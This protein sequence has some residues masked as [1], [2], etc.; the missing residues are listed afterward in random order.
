MGL[1]LRVVRKA[2]FEPQDAPKLT[3]E[4]LQGQILIADNLI[5]AN[6]GLQSAVDVALANIGGQ[7]GGEAG[8]ILLQALSTKA[9]NDALGKVETPLLQQ[10]VNY[11]NVDQSIADIAFKPSFTMSNPDAIAMAKKQAGDLAVQLTKE[12]HD[13]IRNLTALA[14]D[15]NYTVDQLG[16]KLRNHIGL[17]DKW[18]KAVENRYETTYKDFIKQGF[19]KTTAQALAQKAS[20]DYHARL[21]RKR[22]LMIAR[23]EVLRAEND[24]RWLGWKSAID[25]GYADPNS[26][27]RWIVRPVGACEICQS[28]NGTEIPYDQ[29]FGFGQLMPPRHPNCRCTAVLVPPPADYVPPTPPKNL[30]NPSGYTD[31]GIFTG[32]EGGKLPASAPEF[33]KPVAW[34]GQLDVGDLVYFD[35]MQ[36]TNGYEISSVKGTKVYYKTKTGTTAINVGDLLARG[37]AVAIIPGPVKLAKVTIKADIGAYA[38][39]GVPKEAVAVN[40]ITSVHVGDTLYTSTLKPGQSMSVLVVDVPNNRLKVVGATGSTYWTPFN[41]TKNQYAVVASS[42]KVKAALGLPQDNVTAPKA[43]TKTAA[44]DPVVVQVYEPKQGDVV[45]IKGD[46]STY[47]IKGFTSSNKVVLLDNNKFVMKTDILG[48]PSGAKVTASDGKVMIVKEVKG[49]KVTFQDGS[50]DL[51]SN[52]KPAHNFDVVGTTKTTFDPPPPPVQMTTASYMIDAN[53]VL[54]KQ[55]QGPTGSNVKPP[56]GFWTGTDGK[57]RYVK[58][59]ENPEQVF[60]E[61]VAN[62]MY[63]ELGI[64]VPETS[65]SVRIN[66]KTGEQEFLIVTEIVEITDSL[67][68]YNI[69]KDYAEQILDG[70][71]VDLWLANYDAVGTGWDNVVISNGKIVRIDQGGSMFFRAQGKPKDA[72]VLADTDPMQY[73]EKNAYYRDVFDAAG[74]KPNEIDS[75]AFFK[76]LDDVIAKHGGMDN[77]ILDIWGTM[78]EDSV[79]LKVGLPKPVENVSLPSYAKLL[80]MRLEGLKKAYGYK[81]QPE[82]VAPSKPVIDTG[83]TPPKTKFETGDSIQFND[84]E[85]GM[86]FANKDKT[87]IFKVTGFTKDSADGSKLIEYEILEGIKRG[88]KGLEISDDKWGTLVLADKQ[89]TYMKRGYS[90]KPKNSDSPDMTSIGEPVHSPASGNDGFVVDVTE[91]GTYIKWNGI[92]DDAFFPTDMAAKYAANGTFTKPPQNMPEFDQL[93][94]GMTFKVTSSSGTPVVVKVMDVQPDGVILKSSFVEIKNGVAT[95]VDKTDGHSIATYNALK[96]AVKVNDVSSPQP[97]PSIPVY[98]KDLDPTPGMSFI[99]E[100]GSLEAKIITSNDKGVIYVDKNSGEYV[101]V[102]KQDWETQFGKY[103]ITTPVPETITLP[104]KYLWQPKTNGVTGVVDMPGVSFKIKWMSGNFVNLEDAAGNVYKKVPKKALTGPTPGMPFKKKMSGGDIEDFFIIG[105]TQKGSNQFKV[106]QPD[107]SIKSSWLDLDKMSWQS[108]NSNMPSGVVPKGMV[109]GSSVEKPPEPVKAK[110]AAKL[111]PMLKLGGIVGHTDFPNNTYKVVSISPNGLEF[112]I[113]ASTGKTFTTSANKLDAFGKGSILKIDGTKL[114]VMNVQ[115]VEGGDFELTFSNGSKKNLSYLVK[116]YEIGDGSV[117][118]ANKQGTAVEYSGPYATAKPKTTSYQTAQVSYGVEYSHADNAITFATNDEGTNWGRKNS[119]KWRQGLTND[120]EA[121]IGRYTGSYYETTN[122]FLRNNT[123]E[124]KP[125][126]FSSAPGDLTRTIEQMKSALSKSIMEE[127]VIVNRGISVSSE[128]LAA[129]RNLPE[130]ALIF[131]PAF[132]STSVGPSAAFSGNV[133][134]RI[135]VQK[136]Q[137]A[138][139]VANISM[140]KGEREF[141][142]QAGSVMRVDKVHPSSSYGATIIDVTVVEQYPLEGVPD[143]SKIAIQAVKKGTH[144]LFAILADLTL[145]RI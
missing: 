41:P 136:G 45:A 64:P 110:P 27:K 37:K 12:Q 8:N 109:P 43:P 69:Q 120:E 131:D 57:K 34:N 97:D 100:D 35:G 61:L 73:Y 49:N 25:E 6:A 80:K 103:Q 36:G 121:A 138:G 4:Q 140:H 11:A 142:I 70:F 76:N 93:K 104:K 53:I 90:P 115:P 94:K 108:A 116:G 127:D 75:T 18:A 71:L 44:G 145:G 91:S 55:T 40:K 21:I 139:Y 84:V 59:Y 89:F 99:N 1:R 48:L 26:F 2:D 56:S 13:I 74:T 46:T 68:K 33:A 20:A 63:R 133:I 10:I 23:T 144:S 95:V 98:V 83:S 106:I 78:R 66:P 87:V 39:V 113:E 117:N 79:T 52:L 72:A 86:I 15:G 96:S 5:Q 122:K 47:K 111:K 135:K 123:T 28:L 24:G 88:T 114:E 16:M 107:G 81:T 62:K 30:L 129:Y 58:L 126:D 14:V 19:D 32:N 134:L 9:W 65:V 42:N 31:N 60:S 82:P 130:G 54:G 137:Q 17:F 119:A 67:N 141:L 50:F 92:E 77:W 118:I 7:V 29:P 125:V 22:S 102:S 124:G 105:P 51:V 38:P 101:L 132:M 143:A 85:V 3:P 112:T 128:M